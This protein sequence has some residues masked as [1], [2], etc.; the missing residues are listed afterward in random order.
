MRKYQS[1]FKS[2]TDEMKHVSNQNASV[3]LALNEKVAQRYQ[4]DDQFCNDPRASQPRSKRKSKKS[5][6]NPCSSVFEMVTELRNDLNILDANKQKLKGMM[7]AEERKIDHFMSYQIYMNMLIF[8]QTV[9]FYMV[10]RATIYDEY[11][12]KPYLYY[13]WSIF[14]LVSILII[15]GRITQKPI[16]LKLGFHIQTI[17]KL[18]IILDFAERTFLDD[19]SEVIINQ[20]MLTIAFFCVYFI[21]FCIL[22]KAYVHVPMSIIYQILIQFALFSMFYGQQLGHEKRFSYV[23]E[24]QMRNVL[25]MAMLFVLCQYCC[26][27]MILYYR[28][29]LHKSIGQLQLA[30]ESL[31]VIVNELNE[32]IIL[33]TEEGNFGFCN[34]LGLKL[35][36]PVKQ[37]L[38][39]N[40]KQFDCFLNELSSF[41]HLL[42]SSD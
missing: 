17:D 34:K 15:I 29:Q 7:T 36:E 28:T 40:D 13:H 16:F 23:W 22:E 21:P 19:L 12:N 42:Q 33:R 11:R 35:I 24:N 3:E 32:G 37:D 25:K 1:V 2:K 10:A 26:Y 5:C 8:T 18:F 20:Q 31:R 14:M 6:S 4:V 39:P 9:K 38:F 27:F 30:K 41:D